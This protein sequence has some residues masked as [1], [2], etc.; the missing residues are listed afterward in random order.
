MN[1]IVL[2]HRG[3]LLTHGLLLIVAVSWQLTSRPDLEGLILALLTALPLLLPWPG[4]LRGKRYTHAWGTLC[5]LPYL[6]IGIVEAVANP[7]GR[8]WS[9]A[10]LV[11]SLLFFTALVLYLRVT[12]PVP[13][14]SVPG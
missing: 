14:P 8:W 7:A 12:R 2:V 5:V 6:I 13:A 3:V 9:G 4:L 10:C 11:L 1:S